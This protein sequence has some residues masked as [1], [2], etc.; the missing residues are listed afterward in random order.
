M[1]I[2]TVGC[3]RQST[4]ESE[5]YEIVVAGDRGQTILLSTKTGETWRLADAG[6]IKIAKLA[7]AATPIDD[8][9][10][11]I[12]LKAEL[13]RRIK[14]YETLVQNEKAKSIASALAR[15]ETARDEA[16]AA[17]QRLLPESL[18][19][20]P[21]DAEKGNWVKVLEKLR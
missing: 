15:G 10:R 16:R 18:G 2:T 1:T 21:P 14:V 11:R 13:A 17:L 3:N 8:E 6:W 7:D 20:L 5:R 4:A 19:E 9:S 12:E